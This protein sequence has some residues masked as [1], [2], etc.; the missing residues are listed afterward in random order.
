MKTSSLL[1]PRESLGK[2]VQHVLPAIPSLQ[3]EHL[4]VTSE[5]LLIRASSTQAANVCPLCGSST[6]RV[7]SRYERTFQDLPWGN[8]RVR[9]RICV[10]RF[11]CPNTACG[12]RIF[13]ER[14][15]PLAKPYARRT[16]R[17]C[18]ALLKIAWAEGG[19]AGERQS[20]AQG[21]P[22]CAATLLSLL[23]QAAEADLPT[24]RVLG[25]DD[26]GFAA[27]HPTGTLLV[28]LERHRPVDVLLGSDD[29]VLARW[30]PSHP[31]VEIICRD[32]GA[33]YARGA[34]EGAPH[35]R[36]VL[37]RWHLLKNVGE[38]LQRAVAQY[39][40]ILGQADQEVKASLPKPHVPL[41]SEGKSAGKQRKPPR[42]KPA[43]PSPQRA[44]QLNMFQH[45]QELAAQGY[46]PYDIRNMLHLHKH[47][48]SKYLHM[49]HFVDHRH[50]PVGSSVEPYRE[51]L[52]ARWAQG[53]VM[54]KTLWLELQEL[55]FSG[56][57][58]SVWNFVRDWPLPP[59]AQ[60]CASASPPAARHTVQPRISKRSPWQV[61]RL[62]LRPQEDLGETDATYWEAVCRL[63]PKLA[64]ASML[65]SQFVQIVR[66][67]K[68]KELAPWLHEAKTCP[69]EAFR[70][71]ARGLE[72]EYAA[73]SAA[74]S[75]PWSTGQVEG[76]ITRL[77]LLKRQMY[78]RAN[79]DLLRLRV[80][81]PT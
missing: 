78:G 51:Y 31:R 77:K 32:R 26:W 81:H 55:G 34:K 57:Y 30:L 76:H 2:L 13:T 61:A 62:L 65:S 41:P 39:V 15:A 79:I 11:F 43:T 59:G 21:M 47:T 80:L 35:A 54:I 42:R 71:F 28:D 56:C 38:V 4:E 52:E 60:P 48:V 36:Q 22:V 12:R 1:K 19:E 23:R 50:C 70:R 8:L 20:K 3:V 29:R 68:C 63:A 27:A 58:K 53:P 6:T 64:L 40:D 25:V 66:E 16:L 45:V 5:G 69:L 73:L 18:E 14:M 37:D 10:R 49:E 33:S 46:S 17:L 72:K 44:W 75:E 74:L 9:L 67:R 24:P 7:H